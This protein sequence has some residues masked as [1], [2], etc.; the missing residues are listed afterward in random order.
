MFGRV[1]V[2][3]RGP[4]RCRGADQFSQA[5]ADLSSKSNFLL[6]SSSPFAMAVEQMVSDGPI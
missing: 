5:I 2:F 3:K 6:I 1:R 4:D